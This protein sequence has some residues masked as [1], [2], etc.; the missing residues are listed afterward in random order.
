MKIST[1]KQ[2]LRLLLRQR[3][4]QYHTTIDQSVVTQ[5]LI[6][7]WHQLS[8]IITIKPD[9][10]IAGYY[11][12]GSE[13]SLLGLLE[14][15]YHQGY[16]V[17]LPAVTGSYHLDFIVWAPSTRM[18]KDSLDIPIPQDLNQKLIP[19]IILTP[20]LGFDHQ[21][22]RLGQ[23]QGYYDTAL[24]DLKKQKEIIAIGTGYS[25]QYLDNIPI[26]AKDYPMDYILTPEKLFICNKD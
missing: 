3:R 15:L 20:L 11:P 23:G 6:K 13:L 24:W 7:Q 1:G 10:V 19:D 16:S 8:S 22:H 9:A 17:T 4:R 25:C 26:Y 18:T 2:K 21:G 12:I 5:N 14:Y